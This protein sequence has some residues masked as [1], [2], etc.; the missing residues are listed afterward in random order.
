M[1]SV[2]V[3]VVPR[4]GASPTGARDGLASCVADFARWYA[5]PQPEVRRCLLAAGTGVD[6]PKPERGSV[7]LWFH[8]ADSTAGR[9]AAHWAR[10]YLATCGDAAAAWLR[11]SGMEPDLSAFRLEREMRAD[12]AWCAGTHFELDRRARA[13]SGDDDELEIAKL[14]V[15]ERARLERAIEGDDCACAL[16][17]ALRMDPEAEA[18]WFAAAAE[19]RVHP[20]VM[21]L[22]RSGYHVGRRAPS[23]GL[24]EAVFEAANHPQ[25]TEQVGQIAQELAERLSDPERGAVLEGA[26]QRGGAAGAAALKAWV[27]AA[28]EATEIDPILR[29]RLV[30][31]LA[32][33]DPSGIAL[34]L[35]GPWLDRDRD[36][37][38][39][40]AL[41]LP[42]IE[43]EYTTRT[44]IQTLA[45]NLDLSALGTHAREAIATAL[46]RPALS[47]RKDLGPVRAA[48]R[49][50]ARPAE[51]TPRRR[52]GATARGQIGAK[53]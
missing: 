50:L 48:M 5:E 13:L 3:P 27:I 11:R 8:D 4:A 23:R 44:A 31:G 39:A 36:V 10:L 19:G 32:G 15:A 16:C 20:G 47:K 52:R 45:A 17:M 29:R 28:G 42:R 49:A 41:A 21:T 43:S 25:A 2:R 33:R 35:R 18:E 40:L 24:V 7:D 46:A 30:E 51:T 22:V 37:L 1:F 53:R 34:H 38:E 26:F 6:A 14:P 12:F 9:L